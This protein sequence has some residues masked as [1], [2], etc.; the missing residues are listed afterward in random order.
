MVVLAHGLGAPRHARLDA[1]AE[2]LAEA[3]LPVLLFDYR[4]L[5]ASE[6]KPR[7]LVDIPRQLEDW[8][9]AVAYARGISW[10]DPERVALFGTSFGGGHALL[11]AAEDGRIAAVVAQTPFLDG[12]AR[13]DYRPKGLALAATLLA[14]YC[15][16][17]AGRLGLPPINI[18][19]CAA[20]GGIGVLTTPDA[21]YGF[22]LLNVDGTGLN[23]APA[24]IILQIPNHRPA[25]RARD[26]RCPVLY[27]LCIEDTLS[28]Y[29]VAKRTVDATPTAEVH[30]YSGGHF[31]VYEPGGA[32]FQ[33]A[34]MA[35]IAFLRRC[36]SER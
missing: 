4:H 7:Q 30:T 26:V 13:I 34:T 3:G 14:A 31:D 17:V 29:R 1:T 20:Q 35:E 19:I 10:T 21:L 25:L 28:P 2:A 23:Y 32:I 12:R 36:L 9:S 18:P 27:V 6:G 11:T 15:D 16:R 33:E 5:G 8:R 24:R 22:R